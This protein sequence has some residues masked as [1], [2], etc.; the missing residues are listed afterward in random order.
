MLVVE[1]KHHIRVEM[2]GEGTDRIV[3][4]IK[5]E[6]PDAEIFPNPEQDFDTDEFIPV[7]ETGLYQDMKRKWHGGITLRIR[8]ENA[9]M[10]L[11]ELSEKT[12]IAVSNLSAM[13]NGRRPMGV[14]TAKRLAAVFDV[15]VDDFVQT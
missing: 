10:T 11:D 5:R 7:E 8:R 9:E 2:V 15:P 6:Y 1:K 3:E 12:G 4:I 13:E 14:R